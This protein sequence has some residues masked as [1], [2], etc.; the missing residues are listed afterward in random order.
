VFASN[1]G[2]ALT[3]SGA[4]TRVVD[5]VITANQGRGIDVGAGGITVSRNSVYDN[6]RLGIDTAAAGANGRG[7]RGGGR[8]RGAAPGTPADAAPAQAGGRAGAQPASAP[9]TLP[10]PPVVSESSRW[11]DTELLLIGTLDGQPGHRYQ[12]QLFVSRAADRHQGDESG[13]GEGEKYIG[14]A[15]AMT[16]GSG[17]ASFRL[18][19]KVPDIFGDGQGTGFVTATA[20]D[21][22]G[23]TSRYSR[24]IQLRRSASP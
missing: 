7:G 10:S 3:V 22:A 21:E 1:G 8:G 2:D 20:T 19:L 4:R 14:T 5:N 24:S 16:D 13:W 12:V 23:S 9:L 17:R 18:M 6:G 15:V 11:T